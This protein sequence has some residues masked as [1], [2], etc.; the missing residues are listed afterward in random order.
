MG[1]LE[2]DIKANIAAVQGNAARFEQQKARQPQ[3]GPREIGYREVEKLDERGKPAGKLIVE[4]G[5]IHTA[6][7]S[8]S[9]L[10]KRKSPPRFAAGGLV[11]DSD[12]NFVDPR[13]ASGESG[14]VSSK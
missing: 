11:L 13:G 6:E 4:R 14:L 7:S 10:G 8:E 2:D 5:G 1:K 9:I 3:S 12:G